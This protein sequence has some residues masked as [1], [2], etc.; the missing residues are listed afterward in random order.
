[1]EMGIGFKVAGNAQ[2]KRAGVCASA[3]GFDSKRSSPFI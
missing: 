1:M 2:S 3:A